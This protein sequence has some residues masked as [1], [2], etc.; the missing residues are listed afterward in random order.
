[1]HLPVTHQDIAQKLGIS[2]TLVTQALHGTRSSAISPVTRAEVQSMALQLGYRPRNVTTHN[3]G[4][5]ASLSNLHTVS[6]FISH[7]E[8]SLRERGYRLTLAGTEDVDGYDLSDALNPKTVDGVLI[9]DWWGGKVV[10][11][12]PPNM[13]YVVMSDEDG[14]G[15][16]CDVVAA[17]SFVSF[18]RMVQYLLEKGHRHI[19]LMTATLQSRFYRR[20]SQGAQEAVT[21]SGLKN[22]K[23]QIVEIAYQDAPECT[24]RLMQQKKPPTAILAADLWRATSVLFTLRAAGYR[25]PEDVSFLSYADSRQFESL[26]P[27]V[28]VTDQF[29]PELAEK[30][31]ERLLQ[32]I[33]QPETVPRQTLVAGSI[34]ERETV[35]PPPRARQINTGLSI[36]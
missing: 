20:M 3:I 17:D 12:L 9:S 15:E 33:R 7:A 28:T 22:A 27:A 21:N 18:A 8:K 36:I 32:K 14:V 4:F 13:P 24:L 34:I 11:A 5:T 6:D 26:R 23:L 16:E 29:R 2:R 10:A 25:V 30:A 19:A 1:M 31:V 35:G